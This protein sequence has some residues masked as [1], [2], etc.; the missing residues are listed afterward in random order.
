MS[1]R[2]SSAPLLHALLKELASFIPD[3]FP[4]LSGEG[5]RQAMLKLVEIMYLFGIGCP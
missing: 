5:L 2:Q 4:G 1:K 3:S